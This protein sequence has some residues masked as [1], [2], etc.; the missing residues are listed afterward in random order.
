MTFSVTRPAESEEIFVSMRGV[1]NIHTSISEL[2]AKPEPSIATMSSPTTLIFPS[3]SN[4]MMSPLAEI[5]ENVT[6]MP[7]APTVILLFDRV[8]VAMVAL[9]PTITTPSPGSAAGV[10][11]AGTVVVVVDVVDEVELDV[12]APLFVSPP[13]DGFEGDPELEPLVELFTAALG[14]VVVVAGSD[15]RPLTV[16]VT[17]LNPVREAITETVDVADGANPDTVI[18]A[19]ERATLAP[20]VAVSE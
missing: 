9:P 19:P 17:G 12:V 13:L 1:E 4:G 20:F 14:T 2:G 10:S 7:A 5:P 3:L 15:A 16:A 18:C 8:T 11:G 6:L